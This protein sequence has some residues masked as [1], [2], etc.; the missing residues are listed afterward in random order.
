MGVKHVN[1]AKLAASQKAQQSK[2]RVEKQQ[3]RGAKGF[4]GG[5]N[6][7][8]GASQSQSGQPGRRR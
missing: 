7:H 3:A 8:R 1:A 5:S 4:K 2:L 6:V